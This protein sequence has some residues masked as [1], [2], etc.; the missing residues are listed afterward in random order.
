MELYLVRHGIAVSLGEAGT[1]NDDDRVLSDKGLRRTRAMAQA[2]KAL[3]SAPQT[4]W[5]SPLPRARQTAEILAEA[6]TPEHGMRLAP[7]LTPNVQGRAS[8]EWL[9]G[10]PPCD[11]LML[12]G[13]S[14]GMER[15]ASLLL[16]GRATLKTDFKKA[17]VMRLWCEGPLRLGA[18]TLEWFLPP[19][20]VRKL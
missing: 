2:L 11:S 13:H 12:V 9:A 3:E 15:L 6:L 1:E 16:T 7:A 18:A 10:L 14:P 17:A 8:F 4:I 19:G 20:I 5:S